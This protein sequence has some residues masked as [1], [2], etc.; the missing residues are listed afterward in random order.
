LK[1]NHLGFFLHTLKS[2]YG[3]NMFLWNVDWFSA[4]YPA[5]DPI[6]QNFSTPRKTHSRT[7]TY[8]DFHHYT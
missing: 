1:I 2:E 6:L 4:D 5:L 8:K 7:E 3:G